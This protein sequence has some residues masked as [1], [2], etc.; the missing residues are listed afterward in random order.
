MDSPRRS[1]IVA[2]FRAIGKLP[3]KATRKQTARENPA[4]DGRTYSPG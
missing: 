3:F 4:P 1:W 2:N